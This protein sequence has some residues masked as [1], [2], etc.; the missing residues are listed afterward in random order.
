MPQSEISFDQIPAQL[1]ACGNLFLYTA[2]HMDVAGNPSMT[3]D[4][5]FEIRE[6]NRFY[7]AELGLLRKRYLDG[8]FSLTEARILY[9]IEATPALTAVA[10]RRRLRLDKGYLSRLLTS[11][12]RRRLVSQKAS[13]EDGRERLLG[14]TK[15]GHAKLAELNEQSARQI[16]DLLLPL[17]PDDRE[18]VVKALSQVRTLLRRREPDDVSIVRLTRLSPE[19][20]ELLEEYFEAIGVMQRDTRMAIRQLIQNP[21]TGMWLARL[22]E[23]AVGCVVLRTLEDFPRSGECKRLYVR[24]HARGRGIADALVAAMEQHAQRAGFDW[25]YLDSKDDLTA[26]L[27]LY[28][29][30]GYESCARYNDNPQATVFLRK[31]LQSRGKPKKTV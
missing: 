9:E 16:G 30:L 18:T 2:A 8:E 5:V 14:L 27:G 26:A 10:I 4:Q 17:T 22:E 19:A 25:I 13:G 15:L 3:S 24:P 29:K 28:R 11:L 20:M 23:E 12:T 31:R 6:F 7:T 1:V 21:S